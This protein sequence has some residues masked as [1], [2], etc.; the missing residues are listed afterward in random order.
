MKVMMEEENGKA[1]WLKSVKE[2]RTY[3]FFRWETQSEI[4]TSMNSRKASLRFNYRVLCKNTLENAG[5][6]KLGDDM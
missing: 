3:W 5:F 6:M 4:P 1:F 2:K